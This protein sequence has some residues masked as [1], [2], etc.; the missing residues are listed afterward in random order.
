M[1]R[2]SDVGVEVW[3]GHEGERIL[4]AELVVASSAVPDADVELEAARR[5]G[6]PVWRRPEL[7]EGITRQIA[8]IGPTG[9]HG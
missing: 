4:D 2:L 6:I 9:T 7:L 5:A 3:A 8:T 1:A